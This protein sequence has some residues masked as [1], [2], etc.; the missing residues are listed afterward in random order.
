MTNL[1]YTTRS[2]YQ[3][4]MRILNQQPQW[5]NPDMGADF[6]AHTITIAQGRTQYKVSFEETHGLL[7]A[8]ITHNSK[9]TQD[10]PIATEQ[11]I[12]TLFKGIYQQ[13]A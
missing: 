5:V 8:H 1:D 7:I 2:I 11:D 13:L 4:A 12:E 6:T 9:P 3:T 10:K